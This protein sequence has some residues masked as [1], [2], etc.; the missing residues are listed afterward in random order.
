MVPFLDMSRTQADAVADALADCLTDVLSIS[1]DAYLKKDGFPAIHDGVTLR[2]SQ[3]C[4]LCGERLRV[5]SVLCA[6]CRSKPVVVAGGPSLIRVIWQGSDRALLSRDYWQACAYAE[7][8]FYACEE[9]VSRAQY[10]LRVASGV[11]GGSNVLLDDLEV[12]TW[13]L[14]KEDLSPTPEFKLTGLGTA[15]EG[16]VN[17]VALQW[18]RSIDQSICDCLGVR[19]SS[20]QATWNVVT[21]LA[22]MIAKSVAMTGDAFTVKSV[23]DVMTS[24]RAKTLPERQE[25]I[26]VDARRL[27][28]VES[29]LVQGPSSGDVR[30]AIASGRVQDALLVDELAKLTG[31]PLGDMVAPPGNFNAVEWWRTSTEGLAFLAVVREAIFSVARESDECYGP[32]LELAPRDG[33]SPLPPPPWVHVKA[34]WYL[35]QSM[36]R[37]PRQCECE[38]RT[39]RLCGALVQLL[40]VGDVPCAALASELTHRAC[41]AYVVR[42]SQLLEWARQQVKPAQLLLAFLRAQKQLEE[43]GPFIE[44][45]LAEAI[46]RMSRFSVREVATVVGQKFE[47]LESRIVDRVIGGLPAVWRSRLYADFLPHVLPATLFRFWISRGASPLTSARRS[48]QSQQAELL[49][50]LPLVREWQECPLHDLDITH[51]DVKGNQPALD[52]LKQ[53]VSIR[54]LVRQRR[55]GTRMV[56]TVC[57]RDLSLL[58][59]TKD[60]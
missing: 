18:L 46:A 41:V 8:L 1:S 60:D 22:S 47:E 38:E 42:A 49:F 35:C 57:A 54:R 40:A 12:G 52:F 29:V 28:L 6:R 30:E 37:V 45:E 32:T 7:R 9:A 58:L 23:V 2:A 36:R 39:I 56:F 53:C 13:T 10:L 3:H 31:L 55:L 34:R 16:E 43:S 4:Q 24:L 17:L 33:Q 11:G 19:S 44:D 5:L 51:D 48:L 25:K 21:D 59:S 14:W 50:T 20:G 15:I 26:R 27:R